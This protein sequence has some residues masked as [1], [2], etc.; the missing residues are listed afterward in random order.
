LR[1]LR[2][3]RWTRQSNSRRTCIVR[4]SGVLPVAHTRRRMRSELLLPGPSLCLSHVGENR[5]RT[6]QSPRLGEQLIDG[7]T[8]SAIHCVSVLN[9]SD[10]RRPR[11]WAP[12]RFDARSRGEFAANGARLRVSPAGPRQPDRV[13]RGGLENQAIVRRRGERAGVDHVL[14]TGRR[15]RADQ[16][17]VRRFG[18]GALITLLAVS[19]GFGA[20]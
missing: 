11:R 13:E 19:W 8:G 3:P 5:A 14:G 12:R 18:V 7:A 6:D 16:R 17:A 9:R 1:G 2:V 20:L 10:D 15:P 4:P